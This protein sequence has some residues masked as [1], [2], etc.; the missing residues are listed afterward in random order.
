MMNLHVHVHAMLYVGK[1]YSSA[2]AAADAAVQSLLC[3]WGWCPEPPTGAMLHGDRH[4]DQC[5]LP[6]W[7]HMPMP[8]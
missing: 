5:I 8:L 4:H 3:K 6:P 1:S 7:V 2:A